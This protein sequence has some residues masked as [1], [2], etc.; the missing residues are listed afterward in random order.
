MTAVVILVPGIMGS[1]LKLGDEI[2]WPGPVT[3][4]WFPYRKMKELLRDDLVPTDC[5]RTFSVTNQYQ[6]L[7]DD[8]AICGFSE[9]EGTLAVAAYDWRK[10]NA[11]SARTLA[12]C[13]D[14]ATERHG[15]DVDISLI[16]H[17]MGGLVGRYYLESGHFK[18]RP[19]F[20]RV[21]RLITLGTPHNGAAVALP[22]VLGYEKRLFLNKDQV[23]QASSDP[24]YPAAY[25]LLPPP[26]EPFAWNGAADQQFEPMDIYD[27]EVARSLGLV[28]ANI[29]AARRFRDGLDLE[30]RPKHVRY[31]SF[32]GTRQTTATH[33]LLRPAGRGG[34]RPDAIEE[35]DGGDGTVPTWS[36]FTS[37]LQ[38][39]F[40]GGEHGTMYQNIG[41]RTALGTLLGKPGVLAG[42]PEHVE[43]AV[44]DRVVEPG[45]TVHVII[46]FSRAVQDFTGLLTIE[47]AQ[48]DQTTGRA[49]AF[50]PP[51]Q[52][53]TVGY[54]GLG[55]ET[56]SLQF[57]APDLPGAYRVAF[58]D[59]ASMPP[60]GYDE[61]IV[62]QP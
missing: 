31:F 44:R 25:Q 21:R 5:I 49:V 29:D 40:V 45:D 19:G 41:L 60:S 51:Q 12:E 59:D 6:S 46:G 1:V 38:R 56:M 4:L 16:A 50:D 10:D 3:S 39:Q 17:S 26:G 14:S 54:R 27:A 32:A 52:L 28:A 8:L 43:V 61:L 48:T 24:R 47:R 18:D 30:R 57:Q 53:H 37:A 9:G 2:I 58:R 62:Q 42:L 20:G 11:R 15:S 33:V 55:L 36:A 23:L 22:L 35:E 13:V 34:L 7:I